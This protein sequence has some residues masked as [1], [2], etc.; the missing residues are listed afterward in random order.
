MDLLLDA[1]GEVLSTPLLNFRT[2]N[3]LGMKAI[4]KLAYRDNDLD[5]S[6]QLKLTADQCRELAQQLLAQA[7]ILEMERPTSPQ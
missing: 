3:V 2:A 5:T 6:V 7:D 4:V 1:N